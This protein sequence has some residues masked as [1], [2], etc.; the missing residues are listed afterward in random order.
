MVGGEQEM[1]ATK[2]PR[3]GC[4]GTMHRRLKIKVCCQLFIHLLLKHCWEFGGYLAE[5]KDKEQENQIDAF[6]NHDLHYW[7]GLNDLSTEGN[8][9]QIRFLIFA[10]YSGHFKWAETHQE[11]DYT[12]WIEGE[13]DNM[14]GGQDCVKKSLIHYNH[15][16]GWDDFECDRDS[17]SDCSGVYAL[18]MQKYGH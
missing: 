17:Y 3:R 16:P 18:C 14:N 4:L 6:I 12:N 1:L 9:Y 5:I 15:Y 7:I 8:N 13:P 2:Y 11:A 10:K